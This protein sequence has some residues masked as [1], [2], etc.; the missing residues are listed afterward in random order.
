MIHTED[1]IGA[2]DEP[3][4]ETTNS[5]PAL[6]YKPQRLRCLAPCVCPQGV[7]QL[8]MTAAHE[9][10]VII[11]LHRPMHRND[12]RIEQQ[13]EQGR[14][15]NDDPNEKPKSSPI[16]SPAAGFWLPS[17]DCWQV[18]LQFTCRLP[19]LNR[20]CYYRQLWWRL[21]LEV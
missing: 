16:V 17:A 3:R 9:H 7:S 5:I 21:R 15:Y 12:S 4:S 20:P 2:S 19:S 14:G 6:T 1:H 13:V 18:I 8:N 10:N 11:S